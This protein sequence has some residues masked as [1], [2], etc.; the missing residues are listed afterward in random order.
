MALWAGV[1]VA[2]GR[3]LGRR[4]VVVALLALAS[5]AMVALIERG[6]EPVGA[7][8]RGLTVVFGL[9]VPL[10]SFAVLSIA[11]GR[12]RI[13]ETVWPLARQG[14]RASHL[15]LGLLL[16]AM[17]VA[18]GLAVMTVEISLVLSHGGA[19][20][21]PGTLGL[22]RDAITSGWI[23]A[24]GA[25]AYV[26]WFGLGAAFFRFGR[27]RWI[28]LLADFVLGA[29]SG[30]AAALWPRA[31]LRNL[32]GGE[33][34]LALPQATSSVLLAGMIVVVTLLAALRAGD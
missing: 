4:L 24:L 1:R 7:A 16:G 10:A 27:G 11:T 33:P 29:G 20:Q 3:L 9:V 14:L 22:G 26:A 25:S 6:Y 2:L 5:A 21:G 30:Y 31:Q 13:G 19:S 15:A 18:A 34:V 28:S 32:I 8:T 17:A 23:A 12:A